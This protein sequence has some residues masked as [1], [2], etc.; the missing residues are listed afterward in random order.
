MRS[1]ADVP[2]SPAQRF[3]SALRLQDVSFRSTLVL[4]TCVA[5]TACGPTVATTTAQPRRR[6]SAGATTQSPP[7]A[8]PCT[9]DDVTLTALSISAMTGEHGF[10]LV[11]RDHHHV[12]T[13]RGRPRL[14]FR[15]AEGARVHLGVTRT[16]AYV[17]AI[18]SR[19]LRLGPGESAYAL[20]A[21]YRCDLGDAQVALLAQVAL[22][23]DEASSSVNVRSVDIARCDGPPH[24][25]GQAIAVSPFVLTAKQLQIRQRG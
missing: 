9:A 7:T 23:S 21:K 11:F 17:D 3:E 1:H 25:P 2:A 8:P 13:L 18:P 10:I 12:C 5:L 16:N 15:D 22:P 6:V 20:V 24:G 14:T 19:T 4:L